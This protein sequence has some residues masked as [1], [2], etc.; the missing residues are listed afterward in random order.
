MQFHAIISE[1][2]GKIVRFSGAIR[3]MKYAVL[4][5]LLVFALTV[6]PQP[7]KKSQTVK[8]QAKTTAA[9]KPTGTRS[10]STKTA[11]VKPTP[12]PVPLTEKEQFTK[13]SAYELASD[14]VAALENFITTFPQSEDRGAAVEL[15]TSS[16]SL[17]AE[18]K[19]LSGAT[20]DAV[21]L[22]RTIISEAPHPIPNDLFSDSIARIPTSLYFRGQRGAAIELANLIESKVEDN[23]A[24]LL[25]LADFY[26]N[27]E[28][29][30]E[31]MRIAAKAAA[32]D[33]NSGAVY[34]T[35]ALAHRINFDLDL[36]ADSYAK[37]LERDPESIVAKRGLADMKRALGKP[38]EALP[39]YQELLAKNDRDLQARTGMV[40][41]MFESGQRSEAETEL[42]KALE[43][44]PG[45]VV[46]LAGAAYWYASKGIGNKAVEL[47]QRAVEKEPRYIWSHIALAR[48]LMLQGKPVEAET[49]L[50]KAR[51]YG[52]FPTLEYELASARVAA[53]F[54]R[55][56]AED[57]K[58]QFAITPE[59]NVRTKL[60]G[61]VTRDERSL[62]DLVSFE[63]KAS[64][65]AAVP[66]DSAE[67]SDILKGLLLF[68]NK[69]QAEQ[70]NEAEISAAVDAFTKG[71]DKMKL[72]RQIYAASALLQKQIAIAKVLELTKAA[73]GNTDTALDVPS[74]R[75]AVMASELY[76]ARATAF[77]AND[78]LLIPDVPRPTL[79]SILRGRIE[80][81]AGWALFQQGNYPDSVIRLRRAISVLPD[82]SAWWRSSMWRLGA[83]LAAEGKDAEALNSYIESY[84]T[85]KP[86]FAKYAVVEALYKKVNGSVDGL[87]A[88]IGAQR[89][90]TIS[91][92]PD[93]Q[94][95]PSPSATPTVEAPAVTTPP[96]TTPTETQPTDSTSSPPQ[97]VPESSPVPTKV[98]EEKQAEPP[99][100]TNVPTSVEKTPETKT[101]PV[102]KAT[103]AAVPETKREVEKPKEITSPPPDPTPSPVENE[104][105]ADEP[106]ST[107]NRVADPPPSTDSRSAATKPLFEPIIITIP[108]SRPAKSST[109][110]TTAA[111]PKAETKSSS[112]E[113][114]SARV[115]VIDG[116]EVKGD[117][118]EPC[119]VGVSQENISLINGGGNV[120]LLVNVEAPGDAKNLT[121]T[122]SSA[123]DIQVSLEPEI[124]G[125]PDRRFFIIKSI[126]SSLGVY[127]VTFS[128]GCGKKEIVVTVR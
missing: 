30:A 119:K 128:A 122:S 40:L 20:A 87:E 91:G 115:R 43:Q 69:L 116:L 113:T 6:F 72:H 24:Q 79:S 59:G 64:I 17:I 14:R 124:I 88:K 126:S 99:P 13:A 49:A 63:R 109:D 25:E 21:A 95:S 106:K 97:T 36:S 31:A 68:D 51:A 110:K 44:T 82:K 57:L 66:A 27:T 121:A 83:A 46:L 105:K 35:I 11:L 61:R 12:T 94:P 71:S 93:A 28:N 118:V 53:G 123:K 114:G 5:L 3:F 16:R 50:I 32:K 102:V 75:S 48:G 45:N 104:P 101:D 33:P 2:N 9:K 86:D 22:Y 52:N 92:I 80:E 107:A 96:V 39:L 34:R 125:L 81:I 7:A 98:E 55:E 77:R 23:S 100:V 54:Y 108:S 84:K 62:V 120:G 117:D 90:A 37:S 42:A 74:A 60:G 127:Q 41:A 10:A 67:E 85:D 103:E 18:E 89:V 26:I 56:A 4:S 8:S 111:I 38:Q 70:P 65:F 112:D 1:T 19:L 76:E 73:T 78:F 29:G 47:G 15:L 58:R